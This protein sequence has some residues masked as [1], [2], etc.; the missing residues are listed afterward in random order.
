LPFVLLSDPNHTVAETYGVW[1][2]KRSYGK[3]YFGVVRSHFIIDEGGRIADAQI[4]VS[5]DDSVAR[6][7]AT[8]VGAK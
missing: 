7:V 3:T 6:A 1:Q 5:P 2:E 8:I 4:G